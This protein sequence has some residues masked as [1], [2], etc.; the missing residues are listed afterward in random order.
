MCGN[1]FLRV[2]QI[3][4]LTRDFF[5]MI[6][7]QMNNLL[8]L[9]FLLLHHPWRNEE[10]RHLIAGRKNIFRPFQ[11][12]HWRWWSENFVIQIIRLK[13][14]CNGKS[15]AK[16]AKKRGKKRGFFVANFLEQKLKYFR[17]VALSILC[18]TWQVIETVFLSLISSRNVFQKRTRNE[19]R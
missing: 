15:D 18:V 17:W 4:S 19:V 11:R 3:D 16:V 1:G 14:F 8:L 7:S 13:R 5:T 10:K 9:L 6:Y 2:C 12:H